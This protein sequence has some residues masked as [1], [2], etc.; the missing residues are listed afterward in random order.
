MA[1]DAGVIADKRVFQDLLSLKP[2]PSPRASA[3]CGAQRSIQLRG[4]FE[5][6]RAEESVRTRKNRDYVPYESYAGYVGK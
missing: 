3:I 5:D 2:V 1:D 6:R 4:E